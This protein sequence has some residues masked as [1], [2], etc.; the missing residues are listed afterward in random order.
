MALHR[1]SCD[2]SWYY[3]DWTVHVGNGLAEPDRFTGRAPDHAV[4]HRVHL[5]GRAARRAR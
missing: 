5:Y 1:R 4:D 3:E 2:T